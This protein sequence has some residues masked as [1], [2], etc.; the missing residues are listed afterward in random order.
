[1][2][3]PLPDPDYSPPPSP[4]ATRRPPLSASVEA[5]LR[6]ACTGILQHIKPSGQV[7]EEQANS[8]TSANKPQL[9]YAAIKNSA[10]RTTEGKA[11]T[12]VSKAARSAVTQEP[13]E[14]AAEPID[15]SKYAY[16]PNAPLKDLFGESDAAQYQANVSRRRDDVSVAEPTRARPATARPLSQVVPPEVAFGDAARPRTARRAD[17]ND[18]SGSTP[19]TDN[20]EY[21]WSNSTA[22]TSAVLTPGRS[23]KRASSQLHMEQESASKADAAAVEWMRQELEKRRKQKPVREAPVPAPQA[24]KVDT[25]PPSRTKSIRD[26]IKEYVRPSTARGSRSASR[27]ESRS[28]SRAGSRPATRGSGDED[29]TVSRQPSTRGWRSW[30]RR[31]DDSTD[32]RR[33]STTGSSRGRSETRNGEASKTDVNLNRELPPLPGLDQWKEE[34]PAKT[35][36]I[37]NLW[38]PRSKSRYGARAEDAQSPVDEKEEIISAR[39]GSPAAQKRESSN[40]S[41]VVR[42]KHKPSKI[43]ANPAVYVPSGSPT[44]GDFDHGALVPTNTLDVE[45]RRRSK[46]LHADIPPELGRKVREMASEQGTFDTYASTAVRTNRAASAAHSRNSSGLALGTPRAHSNSVG[47]NSPCTNASFG[48]TTNV[49]QSG[50]SGVTVGLRK[51]SAT[52]LSID[53]AKAAAYDTKHSNVM[54]IKSYASPP[55]VPPKDRKWWSLGKQKQKK[56]MTW[57]EQLEK[58]GIKDGVMVEDQTAGSPIVRY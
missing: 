13:S 56:P 11:N 40:A 29:Q 39:L 16:K 9:D 33:P 36:H 42:P 32:S 55:P 35:R 57:M 24:I 28:A 1:M 51:P 15:P 6:I 48:T 20:A 7:F 21:Q 3:N 25:R 31:K 23:S 37:A 43:N 8:N 19:H 45:Y 5:E 12:R 17:S 22:P 10:V 49:A 46:S 41:T 27:A 50:G 54:D 18:T 44:A 38:N 34:E 52:K 14:G 26:N 30:G 2:K 4:L 53:T 47:S 58:L